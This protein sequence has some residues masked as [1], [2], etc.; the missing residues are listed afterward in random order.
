MSDVENKDVDRR[1]FLSANIECGICEIKI[2]KYFLIILRFISFQKFSSF[3][4]LVIRETI[5]T[6]SSL[7][8]R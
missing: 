1:Y 2:C 3:L 4:S 6:L 5:I 7:S 8:S